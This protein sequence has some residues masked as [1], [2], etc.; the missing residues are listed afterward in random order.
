MSSCDPNEITWIGMRSKSTTRLGGSI[1]FKPYT[2]LPWISCPAAFWT[3]I[4]CRGIFCKWVGNRQICNS[5]HFSP[6]NLFQLDWRLQ[7]IFSQPRLLLCWQKDKK[8][9]N[10]R[11]VCDVGNVERQKSFCQQHITSHYHISAHIVGQGEKDNNSG[12]PH[13]LGGWWEY[14]CKCELQTSHNHYIIWLTKWPD[15][16]TTCF[17]AKI[18]K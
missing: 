18:L 17:F 14:F 7:N 9:A 6:V 3:L 1:I 16:C 13:T 12:R 5:H 11:K 10:S 15:P 8:R 4:F 2:A